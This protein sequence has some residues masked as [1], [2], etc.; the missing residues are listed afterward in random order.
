MEGVF[1][2]IHNIIE[3]YTLFY[4]YIADNTFDKVGEVDTYK[5]R[6]HMHRCKVSENISQRNTDAYHKAAVEEKCNNRST[7]GTQCKVSGVQ[8]CILWH[9]DRI[10]RDKIT[11]KLF[12]QVTGVIQSWKER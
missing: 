12:G 7:T 2:L 10:N 11:C 1:L 5:Y 6:H 9:K 8:E 4:Q 3:P